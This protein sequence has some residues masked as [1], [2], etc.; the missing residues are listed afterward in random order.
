[1]T[2]PVGQPTAGQVALATQGQADQSMTVP[3]V[4]HIA[5]QVGQCHVRLADQLMM[6][7]VVQHITVPAALVM[8]G[9]VGHA[10]Q[11]PAEQGGHARRYV[12]N[13]YSDGLSSALRKQGNRLGKV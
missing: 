8:R 3:V 10:I 1:M 5:D 4:R 12:A 7:P 13:S 11:V 6:V 9:L 2:G